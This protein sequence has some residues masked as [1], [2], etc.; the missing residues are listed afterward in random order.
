M[1]NKFD[2]IIVGGSMVGATLACALANSA[3]KIAIIE[4]HT[5]E[6]FDHQQSHDLRVSALNIASEQ[7]LRN[8][9][10]WQSIIDKRS[11][12]Y[13]RLKTWELDDVR[14]ATEFDCVDSQQDHLGY[15]IENRVI[16]LALLERIQAAENLHL[17]KNSLASIDIQ[18]G[19]TLLTLDDGKEL[20]GKLIVGADGANSM[21]RRAAGIGIHS[22]DYSQS[23]LVINVEMEQ[24]QQDITWQQFTANGPL[25]FLPLTG[26]SASLVWYDSPQKIAQ[27][28]QLDNEALRLQIMQQ[29]PAALGNVQKVLAKGAFPLKRQHAQQYVVPGVALVGDAAHLIHPLAGQGVNIGILDAAQL[30]QT[31]Q[32]AAGDRISS[33]DEYAYNNDNDFSA[34]SVLKDYEQ[35]RRHH[36]LIVMQLMDSF[37]RIFSNQVAPLKVLRNIGL[38]IAQRVPFARKKAMQLAMG[39]TGPLPELARRS[40]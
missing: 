38:G 4:A 20:I 10:V 2:L 27:L 1:E 31:I 12:V 33:A 29:F 11:C 16:Q 19:A 39:I 6:A 32:Q 37:Y 7:V 17:F 23:A 5:P 8:V 35:K 22:W 24:G 26:N 21:V 25:A 30:A 3:L 28:S 36:N 13:R 14:A 18:A 15:I 34:L 9:G 40:E